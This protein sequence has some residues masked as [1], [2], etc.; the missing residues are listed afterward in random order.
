M[1]FIDKHSVQLIVSDSSDGVPLIL[2]ETIQS[3][4]NKK[5]YYK[6]NQN[7]KKIFA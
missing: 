5:K 3:Q 6:L 2:S 4:I 7:D 1:I